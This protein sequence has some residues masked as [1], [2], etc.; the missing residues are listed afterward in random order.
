MGQRTETIYEITGVDVITPDLVDDNECNIDL[1][2]SPDSLKRA[3]GI[4]AF[5]AR[6]NPDPSVGMIRFVI[7]N[8]KGRR[9]HEA[10][11]SVEQNKL[12]LTIRK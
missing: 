6:R 1:G 5:R 4:F 7:M 8:K 12:V 3:A 2:C 9:V 10:N 11:I